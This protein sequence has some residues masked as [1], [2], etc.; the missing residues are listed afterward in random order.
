MLEITYYIIFFRWCTKI[1]EGTEGINDG[2]VSVESARW[3][4]HLY[5]LPCDHF[6]L[7]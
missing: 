1:I 6:Q 7:V 5:T 2:M 4:R 3:G